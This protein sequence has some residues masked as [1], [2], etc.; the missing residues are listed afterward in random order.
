MAGEL[1]GLLFILIGVFFS[2]VGVLGIVR[3]PDVYTRIHSSGKVATL[4][5]FGL[6]IGTAILQPETTVKLIA[7]GLFLLMTSPVGSHAI[8]AAAHRSG[9]PLARF[10]RDDLAE[11]DAKRSR[12]DEE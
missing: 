1:I 3:L 2:S 9:V 7:L 6:I 4:G 12:A 11:R 8:A 10:D 5:I